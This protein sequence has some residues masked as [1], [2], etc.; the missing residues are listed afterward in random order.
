M[1][2]DPEEAQE[3]LDF[4]SGSRDAQIDA[5]WEALRGH[6]QLHKEEAI[7][8]AAQALRDRELTSFQ[9]LRQGG[10]LWETIAAAIDRGVREGSFDRPRRGC[11][12]AILPE[13]RD[14]TP[15]LWRRCLLESLDGEAIEE[16]QALRGAAEWARE[17]LGLAFTRLRRDGLILKGLTVAA[18]EALKMGRIELRNGQM[19][20]REG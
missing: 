12:R 14:Y 13:A 8:T 7:R 16:D 10:P 20:L 3:D 5:V 4:L 18:Q 2:M 11:V 6:G 17:N 19:K 9:R 15:G 1:K